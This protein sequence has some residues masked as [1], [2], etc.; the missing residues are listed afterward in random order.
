MSQSSPDPRLIVS[1]TTPITLSTTFQEIV[2][3][4]SESGKTM[5]TFGKDPVT[6]KFM[7]D[8]NSTT[9]LFTYNEVYPHNFNLL[10]EFRTTSTIISTKATLQLRIAI[11]N[12]VSA[13]V[14]INFP[15]ENQGGYI[16]VYDV[17]LFNFAMNNKPFVLPLYIGDALKVNGFKIYVRLSNATVG[18]TTLDYS[19]ISIQ[20][21]SRN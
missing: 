6:N 4:G 14:D 11:P 12:G 18:G 8:Y 19:S 5:N 20:G 15:F 13:G 9:N 16:D 10:F 1:R 3:N 7:F 2:Y 17:S 21:I